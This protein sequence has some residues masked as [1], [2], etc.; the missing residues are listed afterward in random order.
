MEHDEN[1]NEDNEEIKVEKTHHKKRKVHR[2]VLPGIIILLILAIGGAIIWLYTGNL[3]ASK[4]KVLKALPFPAAIVD[5]KLIPA[6]EVIARVDL[7]KQLA[8]QGGAAA[9]NSQTFT[10]LI[11]SKKMAAVAAKH[12]VSVSSADIDEEYNNIVKQYAQGKEE[13]FKA[14]LDKTYHMAPDRFKSEV[15]KQEL[16]Q[17]QLALWYSQQRD[18]NQESYKIADDLQGKL[19]GGQSFDDVSKAYTQD[20]ST[21]DFAGDSGMIAFDELLPEFRAALKDG[22]VGDVKLVSSRYG[23]H[24]LKILEQNNDGE[25]GS[26][27]IHLQQI[28]I[29]QT[30]FAEWLKQQTDNIRSVQLL[31]F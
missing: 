12:N 21:K 25:S 24:I 3:N 22:K 5:M 1:N 19:N 27:Q 13:D 23:L 18:L 2:F 30:G 16:V 20:E 28:F 26:K 31:K 6:K 14:E 4:E 7:A 11:D 10:Q 8:T 29:K 15:I 17:S 9:D